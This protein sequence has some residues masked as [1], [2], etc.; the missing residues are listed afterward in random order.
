ME[1]APNLFAIE[2]INR[3]E[4]LEKVKKEFSVQLAEKKIEI[5]WQLPKKLELMGNENLLYSLFRNLTDN[6]VRYGGENL[7]I[8]I[9]VYKE[10]ADF[11]YFSFYDTGIGVKNESHLNRIF[12]RFFRISEGRTRDNGGTGLGLSIVKNA[13]LFHKGT[14]SVKNRKEGGLEFLFTLKKDCKKI[15]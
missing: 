10:D 4:L 5:G 7:N 15:D 2:K 14:I 3:E 9:S 6:A 13:V 11:Y 1:E 12:E 8:N